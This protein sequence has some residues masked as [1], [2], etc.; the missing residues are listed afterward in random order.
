[1]S[2]S[3]FVQ[4]PVS[5]S[6]CL[7]PVST[8][9]VFKEYWQPACLKLNLKWIPLFQPGLPLEIEDIPIVIE[10]LK[11]LNEFFLSSSKSNVQMNIREYITER[12]QNLITELDKL[13]ETSFVE[14]YIG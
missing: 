8:E 7:S 3:L 2:I 6:D 10:E 14:A 4:Y 12:I 9:Q 11:Q 13:R 5:G 1:M